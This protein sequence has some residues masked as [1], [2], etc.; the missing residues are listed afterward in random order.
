MSG[1]TKNKRDKVLAYIKDNPGK[2]F[3]RI[4]DDNNLPNKTVEVIIDSL[5]AD[6]MICRRGFNKY[7]SA[8]GNAV[9][10]ACAYYRTSRTE[11]KKRPWEIL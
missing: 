7:S 11:R 10:G 5:I 1:F 8:V 4:A 3:Q 9:L 2:G 6:D